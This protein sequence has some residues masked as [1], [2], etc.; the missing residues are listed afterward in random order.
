MTRNGAAKAVLAAIMLGFG[1]AALAQVPD[2]SGLWSVANGNARIKIAPC[3]NLFWGVLD[4]ARTPDVDKHNPDPSKRNRDVV[5]MPILLAMKP[6]GP[7]EWKGEIY[8]AENGKIYDAKISLVGP[9]ALK[10]A[11]CVLGGLF[12]G[13]QTWERYKEDETNAAP[14]KPAPPP[15][16]TTGAGIAKAPARPPAKGGVGEAGEPDFCSAFSG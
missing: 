10:V 11:G 3:G 5:G 12:C 14:A 7:N 6:N 16:K 13:G 4:W 9:D 15:G 8:N 1:L 2:P